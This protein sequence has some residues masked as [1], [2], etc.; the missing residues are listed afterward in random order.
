M[1]AIEGRKLRCYEFDT[2]I[3][4][5]TERYVEK[6]YRTNNITI[7]TTSKTKVVSE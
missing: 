4:A 2:K 3:F 1:L 5:L 7:N 6:Y